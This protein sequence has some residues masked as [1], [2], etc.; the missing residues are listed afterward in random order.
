M[1]TQMIVQMNADGGKN[2]HLESTAPTEDTGALHRV[3]MIHGF[4]VMARVRGPG[5]CLPQKKP[6]CRPSTSVPGVAEGGKKDEQ[7]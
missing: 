3:R 4:V 5:S 2:C 6:V 1:I 7:G